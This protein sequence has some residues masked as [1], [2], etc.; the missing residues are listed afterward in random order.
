MDISTTTAPDSTQI[1]AEDLLTGPVTVTIT[2]VRSGTTEQP[3]NI[4]LAEFPDRAYRPG[5]SMRRVLVAAW[6]ADSSAYIGRRLVLYRDPDIK[7]GGFATGGV[8]IQAMSHINKPMTLALTVTR[9]KRAAFVVQP[10]PDT[11]ARQTPATVDDLLTAAQNAASV[12][13]LDRIA[14]NAVASLTGD[15]LNAVKAVVTARRTEL[16]DNKTKPAP[17]PEPDDLSWP[18][19][20]QPA[21]DG[22]IVLMSK[23]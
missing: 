9:G 3:V 8:R 12:A 4:D 23:P 1:N 15:D 10:L 11:P 17:T 14:R 19:T 13:E 22:V 20:A 2:A 16:A 21:T 7:F 5:K 6:G 18:E